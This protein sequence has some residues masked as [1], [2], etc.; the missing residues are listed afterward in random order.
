[1]YS[2]QNFQTRAAESVGKFVDEHVRPLTA[3]AVAAL[4]LYAW[5]N[6]FMEDDAFISFRY[7]D[8]LVHGN[9]LVWNPG[10]RVEGYTNFL[11][12]LIMAVPIRLGWDAAVASQILGLICFVVSLLTTFRCLL[13]LVPSRAAALFGMLLL[14]ANYTFSAFATSG[15]ETQL[16]AA[17]L[18]LIAYHWLKGFTGGEW[19]GRGLLASSVLAGAA[20]L[21]R[22]DSAALLAVMFGAIVLDLVRRK[23]GRRHLLAAVACLIVPAIVIAGGW[24]LWKLSY[25]GDLLPNSYYVRVASPTSPSRGVFYMYS[26][27]STY[28]LFPLVVGVIISLPAMFRQRLTHLLAI[29]LMLVLWAIYIILTGGDHMEFRFFVPVFPFIILLFVWASSLWVRFLWISVLSAVLMVAGSMYHQRTYADT[30]D[31]EIAIAPLWQYD[32]SLTREDTDWKLSGLALGK[33]FAPNSG[34]TIGVTPA[35]AIPYYSRLHSVDMLGINDPWV[36]RHGI[37]TGATPGH[38][39]IAPMSYLV[40][41]NVNLVV[42]HPVIIARGA[43]LSRIPIA[44]MDSIIAFRNATFVLI[45]IDSSRDLVTLYLVRNPSVDSAIVRNRWEVVEARIH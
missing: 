20:L 41:R 30:A 5:H 23:V 27:V 45:P 42:A 18:I 14:G 9:G 1:M 11:W 26:F 2:F 21:T 17:L 6:R 37:I 28:F 32:G 13:L 24:L 3:L 25:Y 29:L 10:E 7:A 38:Q 44:P 40:R 39:R 34:V 12:T 15:L 43:Q 22:P 31:P 4:L 36:A 33:A 16:Q 19:S 35:G 8:H